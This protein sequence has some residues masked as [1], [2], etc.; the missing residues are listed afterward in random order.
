[1]PGKR[2]AS[3]AR[4]G[5]QKAVLRCGPVSS[6]PS[7]NPSARLS[8]HV[9]ELATPSIHKDEGLIQGRKH[10]SN[11]FRVKGEDQVFKGG[12]KARR[13]T[14]SCTPIDLPIEPHERRGGANG[15]EGLQ[16]R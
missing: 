14:A 3:R 8:D 6:A 13:H 9:A 10:D 12:A 1:M 5:R 4:R 16:T 11:A 2:K 7:S 15:T